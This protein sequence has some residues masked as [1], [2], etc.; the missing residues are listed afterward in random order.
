MTG[1]YR[2]SLAQST[3]SGRAEPAYEPCGAE[4]R[5]VEDTK[6]NRA[7]GQDIRRLAN[8]PPENTEWQSSGRRQPK[9]S[10]PKKD[11]PRAQKQD[12]VFIQNGQDILQYIR[13]GRYSKRKQAEAELQCSALNLA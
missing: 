3:E 11:N 12:R 4:L 9:G 13:I 6:M 10:P 2:L 5:L 8:G 1:G 7:E